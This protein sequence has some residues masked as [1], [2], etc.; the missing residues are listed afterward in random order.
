M[1]NNFDKRTSERFTA[2]ILM[3]FATAILI[4]LAAVECS[5]AAEQES[6]QQHKANHL[7]RESSP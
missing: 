7:I 4:A 6:E 2:K 5:F 3:V 1:R